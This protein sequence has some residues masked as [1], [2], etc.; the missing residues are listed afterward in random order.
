MGMGGKGGKYRQVFL[1]FFAGCS[2]FIKQRT[3]SGSETYF[4]WYIF[5]T[6]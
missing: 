5:W 3:V 1:Y 4:S 6:G 2:W